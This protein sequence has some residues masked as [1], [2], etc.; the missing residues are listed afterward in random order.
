M[1]KL[2]EVICVD[3]I[4]YAEQ[5]KGEYGTSES[6]TVCSW[7]SGGEVEVGYRNGDFHLTACPKQI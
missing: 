5:E 3:Q 1:P 2:Y 4:C 7:G 6:T